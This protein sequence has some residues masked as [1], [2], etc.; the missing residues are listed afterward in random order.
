M[1]VRG[2]PNWETHHAKIDHDDSV[3]GPCRQFG[4]DCAAGWFAKSSRTSV[5]ELGPAIAAGGTGGA[6]PAACRPSALGE[7]PDESERSRQ[8]GERRAR[9]HDERHLP[10]LLNTGPSPLF[11]RMNPD[12][13]RD[14]LLF[15]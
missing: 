1:I 6:P 13:R 2:G 8:P 7:K 12:V 10:R 11:V 9:P 4:G 15:R 14:P 3:A 5:D